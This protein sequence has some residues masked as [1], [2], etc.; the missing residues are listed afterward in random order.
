MGDLVIR[1]AEEKD[2]HEM[3]ELDK[4]C[5]SVPWS[6][7]SFRAEVTEN[8]RALY[9]VA[10]VDGKIVGYGGIWIIV[11]EG[12]ITNIAVHPDY[13][14]MHIGKE[15]VSLIVDTA[16]KNGVV[17]E[18][19]EVRKGNLP[20]I[21]LYTQLGFKEEGVRKG[22]YEDNGEDAIIMWKRF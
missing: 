10:E 9:I 20:A 21:N 22:Y 6:E 14:R 1:M 17:A 7:V 2:V 8:K 3:A 16:E 18:T 5:F 19:L 15:I 4:L 12:H 11:D 13:R